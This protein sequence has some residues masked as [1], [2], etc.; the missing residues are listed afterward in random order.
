MKNQTLS[1]EEL[2]QIR[3]LCE[4]SKRLGFNWEKGIRVFPVE[5]MNEIAWKQKMLV[6][7]QKCGRAPQ[8]CSSGRNEQRP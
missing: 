6:G 8:Q 2:D 7:I 1:A 3:K 4:V 5:T